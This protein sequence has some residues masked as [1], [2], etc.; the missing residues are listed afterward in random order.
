MEE[1]ERI[2]VSLSIV[3]HLL[4]EDI[5]KESREKERGTKTEK[6]REVSL[7][8]IPGYPVKWRTKCLPSPSQSSNRIGA[9]N[10][11]SDFR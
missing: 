8:G 3:D 6:E 7:Q 2:R 10:T 1:P 9:K 4:R 5:E 11:G